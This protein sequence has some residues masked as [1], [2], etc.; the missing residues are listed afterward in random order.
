MI[1]IRW[2]IY[3]T[4]SF[5]GADLVKKIPMEHVIPLQSAASS[6]PYTPRKHDWSIWRHQLEIPARGE[7]LS[8]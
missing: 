1:W 8:T 2:P 5:Q 6:V 3:N 4:R 7:S